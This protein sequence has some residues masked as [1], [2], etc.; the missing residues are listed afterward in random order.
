M[1]VRAAVNKKYVHNR[2]ASVLRKKLLLRGKVGA[3]GCSYPEPPI[4]LYK[5]YYSTP[6]E[7]LKTLKGKKVKHH[8][9]NLHQL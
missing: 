6:K 4:P 5:L 2:Y 1:C 9:C 8:A 7:M 3:P